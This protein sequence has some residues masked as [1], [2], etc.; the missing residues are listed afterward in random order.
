MKTFSML[1]FFTGKGEPVG[2]SSGVI[3][4]RANGQIISTVAD[5]SITGEAMLQA[6]SKSASFDT[7][8]TVLGDQ[9]WESGRVEFADI[10]S[11]LDVV[12]GTPGKIYSHDNGTAT[13]SISWKVLGGSG[14]FEGATGIVTGNF[15]GYADDT[16]TDHQLF[17]LILPS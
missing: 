4:S 14:F 7:V 5:Q 11:H 1:I 3:R 10:N 13:G 2:F 12:T 17:K 6:P 9:S 15:V 8:V 16:F